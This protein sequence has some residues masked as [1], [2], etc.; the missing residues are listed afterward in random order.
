MLVTVAHMR[1]GLYIAYIYAC[2]SQDNQLLWHLAIGKT[3]LNHKTLFI[4]IHQDDQHNLLH[5]QHLF[6]Q[7]QCII[8]ISPNNSAAV[9]IAAYTHIIHPERTQSSTF[10]LFLFFFFFFFFFFLSFFFSF[11][12]FFFFL[13]LLPFVS[14]G[15]FK[16]LVSKTEQKHVIIH[17][18]VNLKHSTPKHTL[19]TELHVQT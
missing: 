13:L 6:L 14:G 9:C 18:S 1:T 15:H 2:L 12:F 10:F 7:H 5:H 8:I 11:L 16:Q 3:N 19:E 4:C 17:L